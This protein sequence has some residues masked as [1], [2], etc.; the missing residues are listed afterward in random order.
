MRTLEQKYFQPERQTF[1]DV[2]KD[3]R[4]AYHVVIVRESFEQFFMWLFFQ[5]LTAFQ[6]LQYI[7]S[8]LPPPD[9]R[10]YVSSHTQRPNFKACCPSLGIG[11]GNSDLRYHDSMISPVQRM[12]LHPSQ[13]PRRCCNVVDISSGAIYHWQISLPFLY[14]ELRIER[15]LLPD[16]MCRAQIHAQ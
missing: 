6:F 3:L 10:L 12:G 16:G 2:T 1:Q 9:G 4:R 5:E 8:Q 11:Y 7:H 15:R 13:L 14:E